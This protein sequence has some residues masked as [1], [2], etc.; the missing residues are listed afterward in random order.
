MSTNK[1]ITFS[2][3]SLNGEE[4]LESVILNLKLPVHFN[5]ETNVDT[6]NFIIHRAFQT[7]LNN[8]RQ[9]TVKTKTRAEV[10]GGGR[11]PWKQK[12][13]GRAR[14]GSNRSP[15]WK[16]GGV[17]FG[18]K[19]KI[20]SNKINRKERRLAIGALL[21]KKY[22]D[23]TVINSLKITS[24]KTK[25]FLESINNLGINLSEKITI[26]LPIWD[27]NLTYATRNLKNITLV[28]ANNLNIKQLLLTKYIVTTVESLKIIEETYHV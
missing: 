1:E 16:G 12:G 4:N 23:I 25:D 26:I 10:R 22:N 27:L 6:S 15:L 18:P 14:A 8:E 13:T 5:S 24:L 11:K 20:Y 9:G 21:T 19:P 28:R 17:S 3:K 2:V 7:Q